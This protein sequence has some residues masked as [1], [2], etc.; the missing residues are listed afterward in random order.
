MLHPMAWVGWLAAALVALSGTRNPLHLILILLCVVVVDTASAAHRRGGDAV[1]SPLRFALIV[2]PLS[3]LFN[4]LT[5]HFGDTVLFYLP[6]GIPVLGGPVTLEALV[7]G[8][9]NGLV[10]SGILAAFTTVNQALPVRALIRLIPRAFFPVAVVVSIGMTFVPVTTRHFQQIREAQAVR[11]HK[12]RGV[13][14]WLPLMMP[15]LIGGLERALGL[16]EAMTARGF[17]STDGATQDT[18]SR[19]AIVT[20]LAA[21]LGGW[22][23]RLVWGR[24][25]P[26]TALMVLGAL[27]IVGALW[28]MGRRFPHT[29]Y[30]PQPW[31]RRDGTVLLSA[32]VTVAAFALP[33]LDRSAL[34]YYPYPRLSLPAFDPLFGVATLGLLGPALL[35]EKPAEEP[36]LTPNERQG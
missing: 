17:A 5:V 32:A 14:D 16:A 25:T 23:L 9:L 11:G 35:R 30:R 27:M 28:V 21:L 31:T 34:L 10:L 36:A 3:A 12:L 13:R 22:L 26:G 33:G 24:E 15:L 20:G 7:F 4:A 2:I 29:T 6:R 19:V 8:A 18:P 1:L